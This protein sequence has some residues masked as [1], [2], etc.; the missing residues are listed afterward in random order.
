MNRLSPWVRRRHRT[1]PRRFARRAAVVIRQVA[2]PLRD[3]A[4]FFVTTWLGGS[5]FLG[6]LI[7]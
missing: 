1:A 2:P 7:A 5:I 4:R 6:A 3:D